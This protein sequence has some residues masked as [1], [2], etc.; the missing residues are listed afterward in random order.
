MYLDWYWLLIGVLLAGLV[1]FAYQLGR[2]T[3][4]IAQEREA[5]RRERL[6]R[7]YRGE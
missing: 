3:E 5:K 6:L 4:R 1:A 2:T 7:R